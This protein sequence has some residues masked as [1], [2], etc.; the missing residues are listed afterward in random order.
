MKWILLMQLVYSG[1]YDGG[2][3]LDSQYFQTESQCETVASVFLNNPTLGAQRHLYRKA[4]CI[5]LELLQ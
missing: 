3:A 5:K 1:G 4:T 2:V